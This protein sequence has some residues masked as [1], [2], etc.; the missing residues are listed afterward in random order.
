[1]L[2]LKGI[3]IGMFVTL[4]VGP[5]GLL[6][7]QRTINKGWKIGFLASVGAITSD[8]IYSSIAILGIS[9]IGD[10]L[11]RHRNLINGLTGVLF[12]IV[13][14]NI[15]MSGIEKEKV[16]EVNKEELVHPFFIHFLFGLSNPLIFII[17]FTIFTRIGMSINNAKVFLNI[18]FILS[19][20]V[21]SCILWFVI[22]NIIERSKKAFKFESFIV[23]DKIIGS[24]IVLFGIF[25]ILRGIVRF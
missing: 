24:G 10:F 17:F 8:M 12:L 21:G 14:I 6:A 18:I 20:F 7:I 16:K 2:F 25:S 11:N 1:M 3:I 4:P 9:F 13:G 22:T 5:L 15:L 23:I 19:I